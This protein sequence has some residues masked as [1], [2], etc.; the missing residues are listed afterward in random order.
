MDF[1]DVGAVMVEYV[2]PNQ[3]VNQQLCIQVLAKT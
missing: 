2:P 1:F 3:M